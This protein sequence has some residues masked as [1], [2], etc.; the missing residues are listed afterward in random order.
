[1]TSHW[2]LGQ[3]FAHAATLGVLIAA[4]PGCGQVVSSPDADQGDGQDASSAPEADASLPGDEP[5]ARG[6]D[7]GDEEVELTPEWVEL[8]PDDPPSPRRNS[9]ITYDPSA[10]HILLFGGSDDDSHYDETWTWDG[11]RW[12][13]LSPSGSPPGAVLE[14]VMAYDGSAEETYLKG[15]TSGGGAVTETWT[16]DGSSWTKEDDQVLFGGAIAFHATESQMIAFGSTHLWAGSSWGELDPDVEPSNRF[17]HAMV[18]DDAREEILLF[19]GAFE[20]ID[21]GGILD[22]T[23]TWD[24]E[25]WTEVDGEDNDES[26]PS[27]RAGHAMAYHADLEVVILFGGSAGSNVFND[28]WAWDG[29]SWTEL[30]FNETPPPAR[31]DHAM[32]YSEAHEQMLVFGGNEGFDTPEFGDT[33]ALVLTDD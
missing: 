19:G 2:L 16:W 29:Q 1:M 5:D 33:W 10:E 3:G 24:G 31:A 20:D 17:G 6:P 18:Y 11:A 23:W 25:T 28:T 12:D 27:A 14:P 4:L 7:A 26:S 13:E 30:E 15:S 32:A 22:D 21:G 9:A 8:E